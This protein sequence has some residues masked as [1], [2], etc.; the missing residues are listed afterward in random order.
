MGDAEALKLIYHDRTHSYYL[1][2]KRA[3][4]VSTVAKIA[5]DDY[6]IRLWHERMVALGVTIDSNLRE[7]VAMNVENKEALKNLCEDAKKVAKANL[8]ADRG[9]QKHRVLELVL[10]GEEHKLITPQ[11]REDAVI[12][13]R[14]L[15]RYG[16]VPHGR[17]A[18]Q[19]VAYPQYTVTG[20]FD[21]VM[22]FETSDG[23]TILVDLKSGVNAIKYPHS[24]ACQ[25]ALY[26][27]APVIST[28]E[29]RGDRADVTTW[30][31]MPSNMDH[32]VA[33]VLLVDN[34][35]EVGTLHEMDI[36]HGWQAAQL[37]LNLLEWRKQYD[38]GKSI[39]QAVTD[40]FTTAA[41]NA[42]TREELRAI[43]IDASKCRCLTNDLKT[44]MTQRGAEFA[45]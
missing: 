9:S 5:A 38:H 12:L 13:K 11:Q 24:T 43:W 45:A 1:N 18:E 32:E 22:D 37:A 26:N 19:F 35:G 4:S 10:L 30:G 15:D 42:S 39:V 7:N 6:Q 16:L 3:K 28:G 14:T 17:L 23:R 2:G 44:L 31:T 20:R 40:R 29:H 33:Y 34:E 41:M 21:A 25:L 36:R 27:N 8:A